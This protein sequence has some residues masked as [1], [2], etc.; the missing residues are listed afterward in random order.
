MT[1]PGTSLL[2]FPGLSPTQPC[3]QSRAH[4]R[5]QCDPDHYVNED[6]YCTACVTCLEGK[7][8]SFSLTCVLK[9]NPRGRKYQ[10]FVPWRLRLPPWIL[11]IAISSH[12]LHLDFSERPSM[13]PGGRT[14]V[15]TMALGRTLFLVHFCSEEHEDS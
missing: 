8:L 15:F 3:P 7:D 2:F 6:G 10:D 4:C 12:L 13:L 1:W 14:H 9:G 11:R 5:K